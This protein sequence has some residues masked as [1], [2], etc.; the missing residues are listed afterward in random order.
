M[1]DGRSL[2]AALAARLLAPQGVRLI[3]VCDLPLSDS[4][5]LGTAVGA[6]TGDGLLAG[7]LADAAGC[8]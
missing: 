3:N 5:E 4:A 1:T 6:Q 7:A 8:G 2:A